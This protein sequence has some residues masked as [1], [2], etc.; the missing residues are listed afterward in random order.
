[1]RKIFTSALAM[2]LLACDRE[3]I[4]STKNEIEKTASTEIRVAVLGG[5]TGGAFVDGLRSNGVVNSQDSAGTD[6]AEKA[7][8]PKTAEA[9]VILVDATQGPLPITRE[10]VLLCRQ[11]CRGQVIVAFSR[12]ASI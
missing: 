11:F 2:L 3:S 7:K 10:D 12:S 4:Q 6:V 9:A 8:L 5:E 1:M